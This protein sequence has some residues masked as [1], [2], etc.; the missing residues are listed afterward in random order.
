HPIPS[1]TRYMK[2]DFPTG[3]TQY[4]NPQVSAASVTYAAE[5]I[6]D[7]MN[8]WTKVY[9]HTANLDFDASSSSYFEGDTSRLSRMGTDNTPQPSYP[10]ERIVYKLSE[11][12]Y[13]KATAY[14]WNGQGLE[15][16]FEGSPDGVTWNPFSPVITVSQPS[17]TNWQKRVYE[18]S[19]LPSGTNYVRI[20]FSIGGDRPWNPQLSRVEISN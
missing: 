4:W 1:G 18:S 11:A 9:S 5:P 15:M 12:R 8:D 17:G 20:N 13:L 16:L 10:R 14:F 2:V 19:S 3:S 6:I 7:D